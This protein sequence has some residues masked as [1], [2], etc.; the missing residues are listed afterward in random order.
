MVYGD[1]QSIVKENK[2]RYASAAR[3]PR[4]NSSS[5]S[6]SHSM[7]SSGSHKSSTECITWFT[8]CFN[9]SNKEV[10]DALDTFW[11]K[12]LYHSMLNNTLMF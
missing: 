11:V 2:A 12:S 4:Y 3:S 6:S 10:K 7:L 5:S 9:A 8:S 1:C